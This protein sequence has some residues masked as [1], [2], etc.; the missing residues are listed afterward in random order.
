MDASHNPH[1]TSPEALMTLLN[2][3]IAGK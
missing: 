2:T 1:I 3:I